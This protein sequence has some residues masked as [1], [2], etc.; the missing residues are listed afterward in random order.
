MNK[1]SCNVTD[2]ANNQKGYCCLDKIHVD[3]PG[4]T[5]S[6]GTCCASFTKK[7]ASASNAV[8]SAHYGTPDTNIDCKAHNCVHNCGCK[9]DASNVRVGC[10]CGSANV[11][12]QTECCTFKSR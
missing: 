6:D 5:V 8:G 12:S 11:M 9:C 2:C 1:L 10:S 7:N 4:A 3:G